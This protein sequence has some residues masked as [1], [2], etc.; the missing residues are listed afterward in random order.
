[1]GEGVLDKQEGSES[2][3]KN[4]LSGSALLLLATIVS[5]SQ[6]NAQSYHVNYG[7]GRVVKQNQ[8]GLF[9]NDPSYISAGCMS[10]SARG[11]APGMTVGFAQSTA[12]TVSWGGFVRQP[13]DGIYNGSDGTVRMDN[14]CL[15]YSDIVVQQEMNRMRKEM[16][17][18]QRMQ[19]QM[20][21]NQRVQQQ[22]NYYMPGSNGGASGY[23]SGGAAGYGSYR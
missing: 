16:A 4:V 11:L 17:R 5:T 1:M 3:W 9:H 6:A 22:G 10:R 12:P 21:Y 14:G 13:G 19:M 20:R 15:N 18:Q 8:T 23:A 2:M 7:N